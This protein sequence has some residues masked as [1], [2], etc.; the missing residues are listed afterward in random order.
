MPPTA[1]ATTRNKVAVK[2]IVKI[3]AVIAFPCFLLFDYVSLIIKNLF[4][5]SF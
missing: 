2:L 5:I 4:S 3:F 1:E